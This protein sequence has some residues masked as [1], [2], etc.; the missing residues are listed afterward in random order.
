MPEFVKQLKLDDAID[1]AVRVIKLLQARCKHF[2]LKI[3]RIDESVQSKIEK[4]VTKETMKKRNEKQR[5][6]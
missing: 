1:N 6:I 4:N 2:F 3:E 5:Y